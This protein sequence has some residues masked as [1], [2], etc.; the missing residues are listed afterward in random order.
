MPDLSEQP[1][2]DLAFPIQHVPDAWRMENRRKIAAIHPGNRFRMMFGLPLLPD[3]PMKETP[4][5]YIANLIAQRDRLSA[6][7]VELKKRLA[8]STTTD[9]WAAEKAAFAEGAVIEFRSSSDFCE[10]LRLQQPDWNECVSP[11]WASS[12]DEFRIQPWW[13]ERKAFA[14]GKKIEVRYKS[15][16]PRTYEW[17]ETSR[18]EWDSPVMEYRVKPWSLPTTPEG[19]SWHRD[20]FTEEDLPEGYRPILMRE[21]WDVGD[22]WFDG[23]DW[24]TVRNTST[25]KDADRLCEQD[26]NK[27]RTKRPLPAPP[28]R[29]I[30][31]T[32]ADFAGMPLVWARN[33][34]TGSD[35]WLVDTVGE[36]SFR[37]SDHLTHWFE[38]C[39]KY[40]EWSTDCV[41][42]HPFTKEAV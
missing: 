2:N 10:R 42:W 28:P 8:E 14:E 33:V 22:T 29:L 36:L 27:H 15:S 11:L 37:T 24:K 20:D 1:D 39:W 32:A 3:A 35:R 38:D 17:S 16:N 31:M 26:S 25:Y 9:K 34:N 23:K 7:I 21:M 12:N 18:P 13:K 6:E 40:L 4:D 19:Q 41:K 30:P 5:T